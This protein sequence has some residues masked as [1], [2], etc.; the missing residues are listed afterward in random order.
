MDDYYCY[1]KIKN[2]AL[3]MIALVAVHIALSIPLG[4]Y[5]NALQAKLAGIELGASG[6]PNAG[7]V[8]QGAV[9]YLLVFAACAV[10]AFITTPYRAG[11][12]RRLTLLPPLAVYLYSAYAE[13]EKITPIGEK[14]G[15][16]YESLE[17]AVFLP[18]FAVAVF[19]ALYI[20]F[21][22]VIPAFRLTQAVG[23]AACIVAILSYFASAM[24]IAYNHTMSILAGS[25][26][27]SDFYTYIV[28]FV[29]DVATYFLM[30][31][32]FMTYCTIKREERWDRL[33]AMAI[34]D[35][36]GYGDGYGGADEYGNTYGYAGAG[37]YSNRYGGGVY[38]DDGDDGGADEYGG[39]RVYRHF[40][41]RLRGRRGGRGRRG[42]ALGVDFGR[43]P[44]REMDWPALLRKREIPDIEEL[45][46]HEMPSKLGHDDYYNSLAAAPMAKPGGTGK[47]GEAKK[48]SLTKMIADTKKVIVG[49][50]S[51]SRPMAAKPAA[52]RKPVAVARSAA[53]GKSAAAARPVPP[54]PAETAQ[55]RPAANQAKAPRPA[56]KPEPIED[57][58][59]VASRSARRAEGDTKRSLS[60]RSSN[61]RARPS[62]RA[63]K[64]SRK[65]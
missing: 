8:S 6:V 25:F 58:P 42:E 35:E 7:D 15:D 19:T 41:S 52:E 3:V 24:F 28:V 1:R 39:G 22:L 31:S 56:A 55:R 47:P 26:G 10:L 54:K 29:L 23:W 34:E 20:V 36:G 38:G 30:L 21:V 40:L 64:K 9:A 63:R 44:G 60:G 33:E 13:Y 43:E 45:K 50:G 5:W 2:T 49:T 17:Y 18:Y 4:Y 37:G 46:E 48:P 53:L 14:F 51:Q 61:R 11:R 32:V 57:K 27:E 59:A 16:L 65:G 12:L 62:A